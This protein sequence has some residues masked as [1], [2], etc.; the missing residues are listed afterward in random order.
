MMTLMVISFIVIV[1]VIAILGYIS[2]S[3]AGIGKF[4]PI[5][6]GAVF[7][8]WLGVGIRQW[9]MFLKWMHKYRE[10]KRLQKSVEDS[11]DFEKGTKEN[12]SAN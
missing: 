10:F 7:L 12:S 11:L 6:G 5:V 9:K 8:V 1:P 3:T 4:I 2:Q